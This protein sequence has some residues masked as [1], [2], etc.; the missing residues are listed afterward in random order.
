MTFNNKLKRIEIG[1]GRLS[2]TIK[3]RFKKLIM[4]MI[5]DEFKSNEAYIG[6]CITADDDIRIDFKIIDYVRDIKPYI[7]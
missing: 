4:K 3:S 6:I 5:E 1:Q 7:E 2:I